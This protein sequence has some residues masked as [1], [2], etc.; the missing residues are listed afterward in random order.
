MKIVLKTKGMHCISC[1]RV[2]QDAL[3]EIDGIKNA[4]TDY[5]NEKTE[6]EFD[7]EKADAKKIMKIIEKAGYEPMAWNENKGGFL[8]RM[9]GG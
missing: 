8:K 2:I 3:I 4:K 5:I 1:E 7:P 6:V 9:F